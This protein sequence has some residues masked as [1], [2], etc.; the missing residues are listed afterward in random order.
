V[1]ITRTPPR[2]FVPDIAIVGER[3]VLSGD[4]R[5]HLRVRRVRPGAQ[6][7]LFDNRGRVF[8]AVVESLS[9]DRVELRVTERR[10]RARESPLDL[11]LAVALLKADKLDL[12]I[13][14]AT[15]LGVRRIVL[16]TCA[17]TLG[18]SSAARIERWRRIAVSAAKQC[19]R[20]VV[21][22]IEG[23]EPLA[24][25]AT[26]RAD[27]RLVCWE[28]AA[29]SDAPP[30]AD[31]LPLAATASSVLIIVGPEGGFA[32]AEI[33]AL[34]DTGAQALSLGPRILRGETAAIVAVTLAQARWGDGAL[35][36]S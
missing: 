5:H 9:S 15:E 3:A 27:L 32:E 7:E 6:V 22:A 35:I 8:D 34:R 20:S 30:L 16:F 19:G 13:E 10:S 17:R 12:V 18:G 4:E 1:S 2:F 36:G 23:P 26:R 14:K 11:T 29:P 31:A 33:I 25:L 21:P 28:A 24:A